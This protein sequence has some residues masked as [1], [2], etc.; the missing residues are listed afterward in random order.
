MLKQGSLGLT[1]M[2]F[3]DKITNGPKHSPWFNV[4]GGTYEEVIKN[5][6]G[7]CNLYGMFSCKC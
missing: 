2:G 3:T 6:F 1:F 7:V 4:F 5:N